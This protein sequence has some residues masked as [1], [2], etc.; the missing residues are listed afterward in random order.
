MYGEGLVK[1]NEFSELKRLRLIAN[2]VEEYIGATD[3]CRR[4]HK[5]TTLKKLLSEYRKFMTE[6]KERCTLC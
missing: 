4:D 6:P 2:F 3:A 1:E 5:L